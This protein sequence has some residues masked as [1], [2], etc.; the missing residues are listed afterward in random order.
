MTG[1]RKSYSD[2]QGK[3]CT[4][5][6]TY[7]TWDNFYESCRY[8]C[9]ECISEISSIG[10]RK[11]NQQLKTDAMDAYG[12]K[13]ACCG[14]QELAFLTIDHV[15]G[16]GSIHRKTLPSSG[17]GPDMYRWLKKNSYPSGFQVLCANC[18]LG[19]FI[20][21]GACPHEAGELNERGS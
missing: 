2:E 7:K 14:E 20:N 17:R 4:L 12:G 6:K 8:N 19:K 18:N 21:K 16:M 9:K 10:A 1:K 5:C 3:V 13:C 15:D 11:R